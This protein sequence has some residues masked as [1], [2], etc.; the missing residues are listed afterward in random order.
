MSTGPLFSTPDWLPVHRDGK[1]LFEYDPTNGRV[2]LRR[3]GRVFIVDLAPLR[4][5]PMMQDARLKQ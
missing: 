5:E 4:S 1:L 3:W 2:R